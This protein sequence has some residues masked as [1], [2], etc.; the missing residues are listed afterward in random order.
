MAWAQ[1]DGQIELTPSDVT[2]FRNWPDN[3][4]H[5]KIVPSAISYSR[6]SAASNCRQ[7]GWSIDDNSKVLRWTKLEFEPRSRLKELEV[8]QEL[9]KGLDLLNA[10]QSD[11]Q[12]TTRNDIPQEVSKKAEDVARDYLNKIAREWYQYMR[13]QGRYTLERVRLD[14]VLTH[15]AVSLSFRS[16]FKVFYLIFRSRIG[17]MKL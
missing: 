7:W 16:V 2:V 5:A 1:A 13:S 4:K 12:S 11:S 14:I 9:V 10:L 3:S 6:S 8:L 17:R 15:P